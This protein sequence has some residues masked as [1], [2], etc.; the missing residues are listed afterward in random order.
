VAGIHNLLLKVFIERDSLKTLV[1]KKNLMISLQYSFICR[2]RVQCYVGEHPKT[3]K[4]VFSRLLDCGVV[5]AVANG[6]VDGGGGCDIVL[7][8][9]V[10]PFSFNFCSCKAK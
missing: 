4:F 8:T 2:W 5:V 6:L 7:G 1:F 3:M 10:A 9:V